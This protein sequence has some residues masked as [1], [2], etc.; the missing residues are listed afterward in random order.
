MHFRLVFNQWDQ[1]ID[2]SQA[3]ILFFKHP[4]VEDTLH[5]VEVIR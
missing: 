5:A 4:F 3:D 2:Q 1:G